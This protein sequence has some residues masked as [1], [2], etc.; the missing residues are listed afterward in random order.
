MWI[1]NMLTQPRVVKYGLKN[2]SGQWVRGPFD[3]TIP[4]AQ[5]QCEYCSC[6]CNDA[7]NACWGER[8]FSIDLQ[9]LPAAPTGENFTF[10]LTGDIDGAICS[11]TIRG[12]GVPSP[13]VNVPVPD[14]WW[15]AFN[16]LRNVP[17]AQALPRLPEFNVGFLGLAPGSPLGARVYC[18]FGC[19]FAAPDE[20]SGY[21]CPPSQG[22]NYCYNS[23]NCGLNPGCV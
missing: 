5:V 4:P 10:H 11:I 19:L 15:A 21:Y 8:H 16:L 9:G 6:I 7:G 3:A 1:G 23:P 14:V 18:G 20:T 17:S 22:G 13:P 2:A 12:S